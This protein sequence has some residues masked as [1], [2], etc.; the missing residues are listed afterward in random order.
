MIGGDLLMILLTDLK[1]VVFLCVDLCSQQPGSGRWQC[2]RV[3]GLA[4]S[5]RIFQQTLSAK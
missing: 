1:C 3:V 5:I 2:A 4:K